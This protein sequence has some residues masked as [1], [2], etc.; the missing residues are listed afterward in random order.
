MGTRTSIEFLSDEQIKS[1]AVVVEDVDCG[2]LIQRQRVLDQSI[3]DRMYIDE[4]ISTAQY[5]AG[6]KMVDAVAR[7]GAEIRSAKLDTEVFTPYNEVGNLMGERRMAFSS[8][9]RFVVRSCGS[10]VANFLMRIIGNV[11]AYPKR[12][13]ERELVAASLSPALD[14]LVRFY[15]IRSARDPRDLARKAVRR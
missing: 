8:P 4:L 5:E 1:R 9:F 13:R 3:F 12:R 7:S 10:E 14:S 15:D 2:G 6:C 11:T